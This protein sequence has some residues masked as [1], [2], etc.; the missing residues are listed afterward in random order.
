[1]RP[2]VWTAAIPSPSTDPQ[3]GRM[4]ETAD[5]CCSLALILLCLFSPFLSLS[6]Q[7]KKVSS[8]EDKKKDKA[9]G[10][11]RV[12]RTFWRTR[13][14]LILCMYVRETCFFAERNQLMEW[15]VVESERSM[16]Q[17]LY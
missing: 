16:K 14:L 9:G 15:E 3:S 11:K 10:E 1:M 17:S 6:K 4:W 7:W 12:Q 2:P 8:G 13:G 5:P